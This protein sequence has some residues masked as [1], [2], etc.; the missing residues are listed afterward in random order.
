MSE[1]KLKSCPFCGGEAEMMGDQYP[2][3]ECLECAV[4]FTANHSYEFDHSDAAS[5]WNARAQGDAGPVA[6]WDGDLGEI[7][8][9][10]EVEQTAYHTIP[11]Y[12]HP[13]KAQAVPEWIKCSDRLPTEKDADSKGQVWV[14]LGVPGISEFVGLRRP[15]SVRELYYNDCAT[16]WMP[17]GLARPQP[18]QEGE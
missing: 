4:G 6:W 8:T 10:F 2:Y 11:V 13:P 16:H 3:V 1:P 5:K 9:S 12:T 15:G 14:Y 7:S 17:T 18:P